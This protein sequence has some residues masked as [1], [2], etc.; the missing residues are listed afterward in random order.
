M[1]V[2]SPLLR[3]R[4]TAQALRLAAPG[5]PALR[6]IEGVAEQ[7]F[8]EWDGQPWSSIAAMRGL[9]MPAL[10][11]LRPPGGESFVDLVGR[12]RSVTGSL[13]GQHPGARI[14]VVAHAGVIRAALAV[15]LDLPPHRALAF[16][17]ETLSLTS[18]TDHGAE[19]WAVDFVNRDA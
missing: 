17:V 7:D 1:L 6:V 14:A 4:A 11:S 10:A 5:L 13:A 9:D 16:G 3:A 2:T 8:G 12:V 19:G 18:L 15:A